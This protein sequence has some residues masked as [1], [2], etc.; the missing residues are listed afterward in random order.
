MP[1]YRRFV[2]WKTLALSEVG[3]KLGTL[4]WGS[5]VLTIANFLC[6]ITKILW[7]QEGMNSGYHSY[8]PNYDRIEDLI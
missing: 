4:Q 7:N 3:A 8:L 6:M 1:R 2:H 5:I